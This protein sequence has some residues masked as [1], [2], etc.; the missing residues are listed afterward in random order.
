MHEKL[1]FHVAGIQ[2]KK[3]SHSSL[4]FVST[5]TGPS[6][7]DLVNLASDGSEIQSGADDFRSIN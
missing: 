3:D 7:D 2:N 6:P 1:T 5:F 4:D